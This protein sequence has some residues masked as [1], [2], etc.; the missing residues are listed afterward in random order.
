MPPSPTSW[1]SLKR[2]N[3]T[4]L[5]SIGE[6]VPALREVAPS[7]CVESGPAAGRIWVS[8]ASAAGCATVSSV[9]TC[10]RGVVGIVPDRLGVSRCGSVARRSRPLSCTGT[11]LLDSKRSSDRL[12][13]L[14]L[15]LARDLREQSY[16][17]RDSCSFSTLSNFNAGLSPGREYSCLRAISMSAASRSAAVPY[18]CVLF[19]SA[20]S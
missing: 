11:Y 1:T 17:P 7:N 16:R 5:T 4:E 2:P 19:Q 3:R 14:D 8:S 12:S 13:E 18:Q 6:R 15:E 10:F 9:A 20:P